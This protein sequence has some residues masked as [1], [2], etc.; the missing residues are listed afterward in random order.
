[1]KTKCIIIEDEPLARDI[2]KNYLDKT[3]DFEIVAE[4]D[5]AL[6][7]LRFLQSNIVELIFLDIQMP[8]LNGIDFLKTLKNPPK[9]IITTAYREFAIEGFELDVVDYL[10][11]PIPFNRFL[12]AIE[13]FY[14]SHMPATKEI[15]VQGE[16]KEYIFVPVERKQV[17]INITDIIFIE[18]MKDYI[19]IN[20]T[21]Q[22]IITKYPIS[23]L[24]KI[25]PENKF[26]R[27][28]KSYIISI[29]KITSV[30]RSS[31]EICKKEFPFGRIYKNNALNKL[32]LLNKI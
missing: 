9:V 8:Q 1:M 4:F 18:G 31:V 29:E 7:A 22:K 24:E 5:N 23:S 14:Q 26:I 13:K 25:L 21:T 16:E 15:I 2:I 19:V 3:E 20:T 30:S 17:K 11:K 10:L 27:I 6:K 12:K 32:N 28:H